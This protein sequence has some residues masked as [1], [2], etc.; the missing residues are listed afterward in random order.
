MAVLR[1]LI[2]LLILILNRVFITGNLTAD[3]ETRSTKSGMA[4]SN[5]RIAVNERFTSRDGKQGERT[6]YVNIVTWDTLAERCSKQLVKGR[7]VTVEGSLQ[8][9]IWEDRDGKTQSRLLVR[10]DQVHI[11]NE[12]TSRSGEGHERRNDSRDRETSG[13][14]GVRESSGTRSKDTAHRKRDYSE[15]RRQ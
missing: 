8:Q 7:R 6:A 14:S 9:E 10:A 12:N 4:V 13:Q 15:S 1:A 5:L 2:L 11:L 3:P